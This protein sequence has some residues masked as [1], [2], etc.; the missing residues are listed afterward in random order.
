[1][2]GT[3]AIQRAATVIAS[4]NFVATLADNFAFDV[5]IGVS[6]VMSE[7]VAHRT[8]EPLSWIFIRR[9]H[10]YV[11]I[12]HIANV[13]KTA[14]RR[15]TQSHTRYSVSVGLLLFDCLI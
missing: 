13:A 1:M 15:E 6:P 3:A 2:K 8:R 7:H 5:N 4:P 9:S 12:D 10:E 11:L 14:P